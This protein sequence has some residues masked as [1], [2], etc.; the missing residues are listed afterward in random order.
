MVAGREHPLFWIGA[1]KLIKAALLVL[2]AVEAFRLIHRDLGASVMQWVSTLH[3]DPD[4]QRLHGLL[5]RIFAVTPEQLR[6]IG[7]GAS[8]YAGLLAAEGGGLLL[9]K[10]W[11]EWLTVGATASFIPFEAYEL[12]HGVTPLRVL[13]VVVNA[14]IVLY[15]WTRIRE[16]RGP[17]EPA[18]A[19]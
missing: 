7:L 10:H 19:M 13:A 14:G 1:F 18:R 16:R 3:L 5:T 9:R 2:V 11:A 15:L 4:G 17:R 8:I 12:F 6:K